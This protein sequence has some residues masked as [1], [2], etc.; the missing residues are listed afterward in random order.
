[1]SA[2]G[3]AS[4]AGEVA[5][6]AKNGALPGGDGVYGAGDACLFSGSATS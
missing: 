5:L 3:G 4:L 1:M 2:P 6:Y